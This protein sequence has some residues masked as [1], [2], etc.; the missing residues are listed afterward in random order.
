MV[1]SCIDIFWGAD[2][3]VSYWNAVGLDFLK[4]FCN[5]RR[6]HDGL[7]ARAMH[8]CASPAALTDGAG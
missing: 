6:V 3:D 4:Y 7:A 1:R 8:P 5:R 2:S